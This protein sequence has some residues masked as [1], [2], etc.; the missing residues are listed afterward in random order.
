MENEGR[1]LAAAT[2]TDPFVALRQRKVPIPPNIQ[3]ETWQTH[4]TDILNPTGEN[5]AYPTLPP[6]MTNTY[7]PISAKE[8]TEAVA[9]LKRNKAAG[10]DGIFNEHIIASCPLLIETWE[11]LFNQCLEL[12]ELPE[13]WRVSI[14]KMLYKGKVTTDDPNSY[15]A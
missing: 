14:I 6:P 8:I 10:P 5:R 7:R 9:G 13:P 2:A 1:K 4:F 11:A 3:M 15:R 12:G